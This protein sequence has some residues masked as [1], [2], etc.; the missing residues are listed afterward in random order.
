MFG[1]WGAARRERIEESRAATA[2][3]ERL[4]LVLEHLAAEAAAVGAWAQERYDQNHLTD[5]FHRGRS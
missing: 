2:K 1:R 4:A 3:S 5:L